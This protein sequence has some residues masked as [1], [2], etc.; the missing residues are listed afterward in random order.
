[1]GDS[2]LMRGVAGTDA[3]G[4][5]AILPIAEAPSSRPPEI[6]WEGTGTVPAPHVVT[7][8]GQYQGSLVTVPGAHLL[9]LVRFAGQVEYGMWFRDVNGADFQVLVHEAVAAPV[10]FDSWTVGWTYNLTGIIGFG[11]NLT[12]NSAPLLQIRGSDDRVPN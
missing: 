10:P 5:R 2:V 7:N 6:V 4:E 9:S 3:A 11:V 12:S 1:M 8:I